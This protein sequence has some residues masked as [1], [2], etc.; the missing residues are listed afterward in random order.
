MLILNKL[1]ADE[2]RGSNLAES[3][4]PHPPVFFVRVANKGVR[5]DAA[6]RAS[7]EEKRLRV[8]PSTPLLSKLWA[9]RAGS[10]KLKGEEKERVHPP[11]VLQK[12]TEVF[13][14]KGFRGTHFFEEC[15]RV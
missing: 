12:S 1:R 13:D 4:Y 8:D 11:S 14:G 6:S 15:G 5:L 2:K 9:N 7:R 3:G 10:S